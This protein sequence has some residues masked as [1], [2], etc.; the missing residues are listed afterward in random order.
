MLREL[1]LQIREFFLLWL[2]ER[3]EVITLLM[4]WCSLP[5]GLAGVSA[6]IYTF[7]FYSTPL[8]EKIA[9][10]TIHV[11]MGFYLVK[12]VLSSLTELHPLKYL[13]RTWFEGFLMLVVAISV[14]LRIFYGHNLIDTTFIR[15]GL[16]LLPSVY[17]LFIQV[18]FLVILLVEMAR[19]ASRLDRIHI[20]PAGL[21]TI[22]FV[23]LIITGTLLLMMPR[24]TVTG[25]IRF[26]DSLFTSTSACC[27]TGL[28][29]VDTASFFTMRGQFIILLLIQLGGINIISFAT[30]FT[31][32]YRNLGGL[33]YQSLM[34]DLLSTDKLA[35]THSLLRRIVMYS[36]MIEGV[37]TLLIY[38]SW[39][40][41]FVDLSS[42][43]QFFYAIFHS[44]SAFNNAGFSLFTDN[45]A[46]EIIGKA[47]VS[48]IIIAL[49]IIFGGL[50]FLVIQ[51]VFSPR[52]ILFRIKHPWRR[53]AT[54]SKVVLLTSGILILAGMFVFLIA[55]HNEAIQGLSWGRK[56]LAAFFQSVVS[57]T[58]GFNSVD[59]S[60]LPTSIIVFFMFLMYVGGSPG[61]TAGG[62][63]TTTFAVLMRSSV[64]TL[65]GEKYLTMFRRNISFD[66]LD[67]AY[68][69]AFYSMAVIMLSAF[70]LTFTEPDVNFVSILF[71]EISAF[72][73]VGLST[74]ITAQMSDSGRLILI[75]SMF[76]GRVGTLTLGMALTRKV[77]FTRQSY[78]TADIPIG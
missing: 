75:M 41:Y 40:D 67:K 50:G 21:L 51:D 43:R 2:Y 60:L 52:S 9:M 64:A 17:V 45:L 28:I 11:T 53:I 12:Y 72:A 46:G 34:K 15:L 20:G 25:G 19:L 62:I 5:V 4:R 3:R 44:I 54:S 56:I 30:F 69:L 8:T 76:I 48:H 73:T 47:W 26:L 70:L 66:T 77:A 29:V 59:L 35:D 1:Y 18:Y 58:A 10:T 37:G 27:V 38:L 33:K 14:L 36:F 74:G 13:R 7:G 61:S 57:R 68:A 71:E 63:K 24:M 22:S 78:P 6:V 55:P 65:R 49:L 23:F 16:P 42:G 32:F 31:S 39:R